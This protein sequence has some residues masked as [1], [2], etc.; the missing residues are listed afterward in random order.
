MVDKLHQQLH[1]QL[2]YL[3]ELEFNNFIII[4]L[5]NNT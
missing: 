5:I 2:T 4:L 1:K 3:F